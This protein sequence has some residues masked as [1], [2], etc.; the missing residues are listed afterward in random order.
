MINSDA[1]AHANVDTTFYFLK[2]E[3]FCS[4]SAFVNLKQM[5]STRLFYH[6]IYFTLYFRSPKGLLR[7]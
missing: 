7:A 2:K 3:S 5:F 1:C 4:L 6:L